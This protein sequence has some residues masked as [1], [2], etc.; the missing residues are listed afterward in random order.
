MMPAMFVVLLSAG[1][2]FAQ[3]NPPA[4]TPAKSGQEQKAKTSSATNDPKAAQGESKNSP[5]T[6]T[7]DSPVTI[8]KSKQDRDAETND[9]EHKA[10]ND[11]WLI[12]W[13]GI[14]ACTTLLLAG[15]TAVLARYTYK[16]WY[17]ASKT[18]ERQAWE[19]TNS[20]RIAN[21]AAWAADR[22]ANAAVRAAEVANREFI[23]SNRPKIIVRRVSLDILTT[24]EGESAQIQYIVSNV[25]NTDATVVESNATTQILKSDYPEVGGSAI[26]PSVLPFSK[27]TDAIPNRSYAPGSTD[28]FI[29]VT[30]SDLSSARWGAVRGHATIIFF[31]YIIYED[32]N[33]VVRRT[34]FC[35]AY[36]PETRR[37]TVADAEH[38][39]AD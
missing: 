15:I 1:C 31:G 29:A 11:R 3:S 19:M 18:S 35:R 37:F 28:A 21:D 10:S 34:Q 14:L 5:L 27:Q 4:P 33:G 24:D 38:E 13:T 36:D 16:L 8:K 2:T 17:D 39:Y 25:G 32:G 30:D 20:L 22:T 6:V 23:S 9:S 26:F 7:I 12:V